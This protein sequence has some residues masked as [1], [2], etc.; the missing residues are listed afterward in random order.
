MK[1][2]KVIAFDGLLING[3]N[4]SQMTYK[5]YK[6]PDINMVERIFSDR[7]EVKLGVPQ[8]YVLG[9]FLLVVAY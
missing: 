2:Y 4:L 9:P 6:N 5:S 1:N 3:L 8:G 7:K